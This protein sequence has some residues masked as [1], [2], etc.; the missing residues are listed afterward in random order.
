MAGNG[1]GKTWAGG[2][3]AAIHATGLYPDWWKGQRFYHQIVA[4]VGGNTNEAVRDISQKM[5]FGDPTEPGAL[6]SGTIPVDLIGKRTSKPGVPNAYDTVLV[7]HISGGWSKIMFR[8][9]EQG[10]KKHMGHRIHYGWLDEEPPQDIWSQYLRATISM[11]GILIITFTPETG[12]TE[13]VNNFMNNIGK[14]QSL[15]QASWDDAPHL[16]KDGQLSDAAKQLEAGFP[17]HEREM[18][19]RGVPS[20]GRGLVFPFTAEQLAVDPFPIPRHWPQII[21][22]DFG[23]DHP[24]AAARLVW[25]RDS[26]V[27]YLIS[28]YRESRAIPAIHAA[29]IQPWGAWIPVAWP[30]DGLNTEKG[31]GD[32]LV[33]AYS[34][35]GLNML[36]FKATNPPDYRQ[37]QQEGE[38]GNSVEASILAM[39]ERMETGRWKVFSTCRLWLQ[40]QRTYHRD[41]QMKLIKVRDDLISASR[42]AHMM[43]RK[44]TT[45]TIKR[46]KRQVSAGATNWG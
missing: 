45:E 4:M 44:A 22:V 8:A 26:D 30:H 17:A 31:T 33:K 42:Y 20:Y 15:I 23:W 10:A 19:R 12:L 32:E 21:G 2:M 24:A 25:D 16:V 1:T 37:G 46:Q 13:V 11:D 40:E 18:R 39:F 29:S 28:E 7:K 36:P 6:G 34:K 41:E 43:L 14:G 35:E 3:D 27:V 5:L 9:Y 38:G